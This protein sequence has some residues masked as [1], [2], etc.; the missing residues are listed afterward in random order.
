[1][2]ISRSGYYAWLKRPC[3]VISEA[4]LN[5]YRRC[6]ELFHESRQ[7]LGSRQLT[8][9]L[10]KEGFRIGRHKVRSL[11]KKLI[12]RVKQGVAYK[13]TTERKHSDKV[14]DNV[15]NE[16]FNPQKRNHS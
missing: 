8:K 9:Q 15:L 6:K 4:E 10:C 7:S 14:A 13:V 12:L 16:P 11:M 3:K 2:K 5:L 1:M